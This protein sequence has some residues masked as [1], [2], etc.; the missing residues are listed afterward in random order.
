MVWHRFW[1]LH[2][3]RRMSQGQ[4]SVSDGIEQTDKNWFNGARTAESFAK[5]ACRV[6]VSHRRI[7]AEKHGIHG[8][9]GTVGTRN[10]IRHIQRLYYSGWETVRLKQENMKQ[11][12][13]NRNASKCLLWS[14]NQLFDCFE[15]FQWGWCHGNRRHGY[16]T[17]LF[18]FFIIL[19]NAIDNCQLIWQFSINCQRYYS[20]YL[21]ILLQC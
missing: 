20:C 16:E 4:K 6:C 21:V 11:Y 18:L 7:R 9:I 13:Y 8:S 1:W 17:G 5:S 2:R 12:R 3:I 15:W 19:C 10:A 14:F